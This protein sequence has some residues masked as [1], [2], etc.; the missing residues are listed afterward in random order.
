ATSRPSFPEPRS[1]AKAK[2][3]APCRAS[4]SADRKRRRPE[5]PHEHTQQGDKPMNKLTRRGLVAALAL[6]TA[7]WQAP[8][9]AAWPEKPI[10]LIWPYAAGGLGY[11]LTR[12]ITD[13]LT[14][15][16]GQP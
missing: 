1:T 13:G 10:K 16:L 3:P 12:V 8:A 4:W 9:F 15:R 7:L 11:N 6:G 2:P 14:E 5:S